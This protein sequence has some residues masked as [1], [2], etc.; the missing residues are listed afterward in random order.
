MLSFFCDKNIKN[1]TEKTI[2]ITDGI[3]S[4]YS[5]GL[6]SA[7]FEKTSLLIGKILNKIKE[8]IVAVAP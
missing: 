6:I 5:A 4:V 7:P 8:I 1:K 2:S 3:K